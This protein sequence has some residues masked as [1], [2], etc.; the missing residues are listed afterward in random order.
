[1]G[2]DKKSGKPFQLQKI[3]WSLSPNACVV[4]GVMSPLTNLPQENLC[5]TL[6]LVASR[7][8]YPF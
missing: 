4:F 3:C 6:Q 8:T 5:R 7:D 1:M 2:F